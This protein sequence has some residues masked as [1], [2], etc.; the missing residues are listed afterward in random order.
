MW[1]DPF[2]HQGCD[3][4]PCSSFCLYRC[5]GDG[6]RGGARDSARVGAGDSA[7]RIGD[8]VR[9]CDYCERGRLC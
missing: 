2:A 5:T 1:V 6:A 7:R 8:N 4:Y 9:C 3:Y